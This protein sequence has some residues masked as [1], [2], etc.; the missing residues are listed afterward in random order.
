MDPTEFRQESRRRW[1]AAAS[2]W[3]AH[4]ELVAEG[5]MPAALWLVDAVAPQPGHR[6]LELAAGTGEVGFLAAEL[7]QPG[8]ELITSDFAP[9][10]LTA[11]Q[12]RAA[13]LGLEGVRFKQIDA[14]SID[15]EAGSLDGV[16]CRWG[17]MLMADPEAALRE[18]R[19]VLKPGGRVALAA[20][21]SADDNPWLS[22]F[23]REL[24][25]LGLAEPSDP[26]APGPF[27]WA[28]P[29]VIDEQLGGVGFVEDIRVDDLAWTLRY[30]GFDA[31]WDTTLD[32]STRTRDA[33]AQ[34]D[35][36]TADRLRER[37]RAAAQPFTAA[38]GA[39][40]MPARSWVA[41]AV[42]CA[43]TVPVA[44]SLPQRRRRGEPAAR[45]HAL[46]GRHLHEVAARL[47]VRDRHGRGAAG[48]PD[49]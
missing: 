4:P 35:E 41:S 33:L 14:E 23:G 19:R 28:E 22:L 43:G 46:V 26:G 34:A 21:T 2:G 40:E 24:E 32:M 5:H 15:I 45:V 9:E 17:Y 16:L 39:L 6:I 48:Q 36:A 7:I 13:K 38:D 11:A 29:G 27:R 12:E 10:M 47:G 31:W 25:D 3:A 18:T 37:L 30:P 8:G 49:A 1:G 42:A 20:W 44:V